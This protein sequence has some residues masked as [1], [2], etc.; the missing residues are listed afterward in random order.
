MTEPADSAHW[1]DPRPRD[2]PGFTQAASAGQLPVIPQAPPGLIPGP[3]AARTFKV[4]LMRLAG[5]VLGVI[6]AM[7]VAMSFHSTWASLLPIGLSWVVFWLTLHWLAAVG[8]RNFQE[9]KHGYTTLVLKY[10]TFKSTTDLRWWITNWRIPW[11]YSGLWILRSDGSVI[12]APTSD[13]EPPGFY[14]SP[15]QTGHYE[16]WTGCTW[17]DQYQR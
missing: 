16:L 17:A 6:I 1:D 10:G 9:F 3:S 8:R 2:V 13:R 12:S 4:F 14:P 5:V 7:R 15:H 11:D